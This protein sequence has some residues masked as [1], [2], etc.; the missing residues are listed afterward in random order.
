MGGWFDKQT[1]Q[2][3]Y[4]KTPKLADKAEFW[5]NLSIDLYEY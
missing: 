5:E 4:H 3:K 2:E 1:I